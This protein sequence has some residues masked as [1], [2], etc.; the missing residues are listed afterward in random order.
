[1]ATRRKGI[2]SMGARRKNLVQAVLDG[3]R[4][5]GAAAVFFHSAVAAHFGFGPTDT[6]V[7]DLLRQS[8]PLTPKQLSERTGMAPA[9]VT[10]IVDRLQ[11]KG[12]V[13]RLPHPEDGRRLLVEFDP[14]AFEELAP[15]FAGIAESM[16]E[17]LKHY[18]DAELALIAEVF[19]EAARRQLALAVEIA[20]S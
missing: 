14:A 13:R 2:P 15:M 3:G 20:G 9:S 11:R 7:L 6:K 1:M 12:F 18:D 5:L 16:T 4:D 19:T 17:M 8:G 10:G